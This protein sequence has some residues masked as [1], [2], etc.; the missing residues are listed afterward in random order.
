MRGVLVGALFLV[1]ACKSSSPVTDDGTVNALCGNGIVDEGETCDGNC[2]PCDDGIACTNDSATGAAETCDLRCTRESIEACADGDGCCPAG[3]NSATDGDCSTSCGD[4]N[5][6]VN[7]TCDPPSSCPA[8]CNDGN[9]CTTDL[10]T[11]SSA[12][13]NAACATSPI[14]ACAAGDGCCPTGCTANN[15]GDCNPSCGNGTVEAGET[16]D[17]KATCPTS[18]NDGNACTT[19]VLMGSSTTCNATC[20]YPAITACTNSDACCPSTCTYAN[21]NDCAPPM[22][23][24]LDQRLVVT[25]IMAPAGVIPGVSNWRIWGTS[26]LRIGPVYTVPF[27]DCGTL[28]G[29]TTGT[30]TNPRARVAR[31][32][33]Q[34][35]LVTTYDLGA[36]TLRGLAAEP[37]GHWG[38]LLWEQDQTAST[39]TLYVRR[40][41]AAGA[42]LF[43]TSLD[44]TLAAPTDFGIGESR[45][46]YGNAR[47]GAYFHVHGISGFAN[48]HEGDALHWVNATTGARTLGWNWGCSHSMSEL[49]RYSPAAN[50]TLPV[51]VTDCYPGTGSGDFATVSIGGIYLNHSERKVRDVDAGC[52]GRVAGE[53]G[54][55]APGVAGWK[56]V[57]NTHQNAAT[58][59]QSSYNTSTMNQDIGFV[60]VANNKTLGSIVWLT[61]TT[62]NEQNS[63]IARWR[64]MGDTTEQYV[65]GWSIAGATPTYRLGRINATGGF[66]EGPLTI[67]TAKWGERDDPFRDHLNGDIVWA[68]FDA[69]GATT[70]RFALLRSGGTA[71]CPQL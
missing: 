70:F 71:T 8:T 15:D 21:D 37:T 41:T 58:M 14:N 53:L 65:V 30:T 69:A 28:V 12:N 22:S 6:D 50:I 60:S 45:L 62:A 17:P 29:Y 57:F 33:A 1:G 52:N 40:Y 36:F 44:D 11:G 66:I 26:S 3:C 34:D 10:L 67:T 32:N 47:Y 63:S 24:P 20:S 31:L 51:C 27:A 39:N 54:S 19:N 9:T 2:E 64:P 61:T 23:T 13:C 7:E 5:I 25:N 49:L 43:S 18:C 35:Q 48:G 46:E 56:L 4:G 59:G 16:C 55:A 38:A 42:Q 68:W